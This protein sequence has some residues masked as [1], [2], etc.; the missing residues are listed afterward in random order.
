MTSVSDGQTGNQIVSQTASQKIR[1]RSCMSNRLRSTAVM[2]NVSD[3]QTDNQTV[4]YM[5]C[6]RSCA[7]IDRLGGS[8]LMVDINDDDSF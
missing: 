3:G 6:G 1:G 7:S 4:R 8:R 5:V 2:M